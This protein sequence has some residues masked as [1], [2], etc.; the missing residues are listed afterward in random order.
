MVVRPVAGRAHLEQGPPARRVGA[1]GATTA[2]PSEDAAK[3]GP[4]AIATAAALFTLEEPGDPT[5]AD[6]CS[7]VQYTEVRC[8]LLP[9]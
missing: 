5:A 6:C 1:G 9:F 8:Q 3:T 2:G 7:A 4:Y